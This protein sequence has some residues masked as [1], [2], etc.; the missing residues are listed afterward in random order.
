MRLA[1]VLLV[2]L[3]AACGSKRGT[4]TTTRDCPTGLVCG[5]DEGRCLAAAGSCAGGRC[6]AGYHCDGSLSLCLEGAADCG[7]GGACGDG[8][9]CSSGRCACEDDGGCRAGERCEGGACVARSCSRDGECA[10]GQICEAGLCTTGCRSAR[11]CADVGPECDL[12]AGAHGLCVECAADDHCEG[13]DVCAR[14]ECRRPCGENR[15]C[16]LG[17]V[18]IDGG[19]APGCDGD[20]DCPASASRCDLAAG[21][22]GACEVVCDG[23]EDCGARRCDVA[24]ATCVD[25]VTNAHCGL[26]NVC[27]DGACSAGCDGDRDCPAARPFCAASACVACRGPSDCGGAECDGGVCANATHELDVLFVID[28]SSSMTEEQEALVAAFGAF[29]EGLGTPLPS[30]HLGVVS[31][32][33]GT[34]PYTGEAC[35]GSG[36]NGLLENTP[37]GACSPPRARYIED[38]PEEGGGRRRNYDGELAAAFACI[39]RLGDDGCGIERHLDAMRAAL[40]GSRPEN[41]GFVRAGA[42]LAVVF[43]A[44]EDDCSAHDARVYDPSQA[45][46]NLTSELGPYT[47]YRCTEFGVRCDGANLPRTA[48]SYTTCVPR[49]DSFL[50]DPAAGVSFLRGL[51]GPGGVTVGVIAGD[52]SPFRVVTTTQGRPRLDSSC[53]GATGRTAVPAVRLQAFAEAF[54]ARGMTTSICA[55]DLATPLRQLGATIRSGLGR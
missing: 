8:Q 46:D 47:S 55:A 53:T 15:D 19:C 41:A 20:R 26:G 52:R 21:L 17:N 18:C 38:V 24:S 50:V 3:S 13:T 25:C 29:V 27:R 39:A 48:G 54:G 35:I 30:L 43:F 28:D 12:A 49:T 9:T 51:K 32:D 5:R 1:L 14:G 11:D 45:L 42:H 44:D 7:P 31:A 33:L 22:Y 2:A 23:D 37:R 34:P 36:D 4:C 40:D 6:P 10:A 16:M